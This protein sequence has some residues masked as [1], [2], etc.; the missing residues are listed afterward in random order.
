MRIFDR[1][2]EHEWWAVA[3][4]CDYATFFHTPLWHR[5]A[6]QSL[7]GHRDITFSAEIENGV[8]AVVPLLRTRR[9]ILDP[10][11]RAV[12][13]FAG[14]Y[15]GPIADGPLE[16]E[17]R[18]RLYEAAGRVTCPL[19]VSGNPL[20]EENANPRGFDRT[21]DTTRVL[22]LDAPFEELFARFS[23]GHRAS[24]TKGRREGVVVRRA[25]SIAD[26]RR[27][28]DVYESALHRWG[29]NATSRYPWSLFAQAHALAAEH[30]DHIILWLG[31]VGGE[32]VAG[33]LMFYW[34][35]HV[36]YWHGA[37][38]EEGRRVSAT[39]VVLA[40]AIADAERRGFQWFD[41]NPSG[42]HQSVEAFKRRFGCEQ[43]SFGRY[44]RSCGRFTVSERIAPL[45]RRSRR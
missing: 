19:L 39:N 27:Y 33:G 2:D 18:A 17:R 43:L 37:S 34:N 3:R 30:P 13:S 20:I 4:A 38:N 15:G 16:P 45:F 41:F 9:S 14:C 26:F 32:V 21:E 5:L 40:E 1:V 29:N 6:E 36:V 28:H 44:R 24:T 22:R 35:R 12:S 42:G 31:E 11:G 10:R 8:R 7:P 23:K 25:G